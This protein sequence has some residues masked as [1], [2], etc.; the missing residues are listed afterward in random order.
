MCLSLAAACIPQ[1]SAA[2]EVPDR[3]V[4]AIKQLMLSSVVPA[5]NAVFAVANEAPKDT[6]GWLTVEKNARA[7]AQNGRQLLQMSPPNG[8]EWLKQARLLFDAAS[9][10]AAAT[11]ASDADKVS[12]AGNAIYE[13]CAACHKIYLLSPH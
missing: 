2:P 11:T 3:P 4:S 7:L 1:S 9:E 6:A 13:T 5:S 10:A 8:E 12:D